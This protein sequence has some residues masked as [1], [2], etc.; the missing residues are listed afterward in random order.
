MAEL[1]LSTAESLKA[2]VAAQ[3][4]PDFHKM[5]IITSLSLGPRSRETSRPIGWTFLRILR[6]WP[7]ALSKVKTY[8]VTLF[9]VRPNARLAFK[10]SQ[11][12]AK[13][14]FIFQPT[15]LSPDTLE[16]TLLPG[17]SV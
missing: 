9:P 11:W 13:S 3:K 14:N 15:V 8:G 10:P 16:G 1:L 2:A 12:E 6:V 5:A 17:A 7:V 4:F